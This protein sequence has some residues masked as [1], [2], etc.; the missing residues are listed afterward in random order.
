MT[1]NEGISDRALAIAAKVETFVRETVIPYERDP[2]RDHHGAPTDELVMEM[3]EQARAAG[4]LTPHILQDGSHLNQRET[5]VVLIKSGLSPLGP[6]ACNTMAPDEGNMYLLGK[7]GSPELKERFLKPMVDGRVR[8]AFFMTEPAD[9]G[10]A[11]FGLSSV[12]MRSRHA[13]FQCGA[14]WLSVGSHCGLSTAVAAC[15]AVSSVSVACP[16]A[17]AAMCRTVM[18]RVRGS[19]T[20]ASY[21]GKKSMTGVSRSRSPSARARPAA[22]EVKLLLSE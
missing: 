13:G 22:V 9:E 17:I 2:R 19:V 1:T 12:L 3:R 20:S 15:S 5:A 8:S 7:E 21:S 16:L 11:G 14:P 4:V 6:L 18:R 10:G